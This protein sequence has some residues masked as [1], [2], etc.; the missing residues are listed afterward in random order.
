MPTP[1]EV[2]EN[3][4]RQFLQLDGVLSISGDNDSEQIKLIVTSDGLDRM[5]NEIG[6]NVAGY[7]VEYQPREDVSAL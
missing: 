5:Q 7:T 3:L 6:F 2:A 1:T 4:R